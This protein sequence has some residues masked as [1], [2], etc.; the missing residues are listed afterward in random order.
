MFRAESNITWYVENIYTK[1]FKGKRTLQIFWL[2]A[3]NIAKSEKMKRPTL[4]ILR[5][6]TEE[7]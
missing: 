1:E 3:T 6:S 2:G 4:N 7:K 5:K